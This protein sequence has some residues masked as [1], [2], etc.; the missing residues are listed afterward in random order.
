MTNFGFERALWAFLLSRV[1]FLL[2]KSLSILT[3][4]HV[5]LRTNSIMVFHPIS[6]ES[7]NKTS[8]PFHEVLRPSAIP[9]LSLTLFRLKFSHSFLLQASFLARATAPLSLI[10]LHPKFRFS[11]SFQKVF[12]LIAIPPSAPIA[13]QLRSIFLKRAQVAL[14][15]TAMAT[16]FLI[17]L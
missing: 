15:A 5:S 14:P 10:W 9:P 1:S 8:S 12:L 4:N 2:S 7:I 3:S 17:S 16:S 13:L 6:F 11:R